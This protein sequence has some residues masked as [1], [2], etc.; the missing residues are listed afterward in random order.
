MNLRKHV[1]QFFRI[2][3]SSKDKKYKDEGG[4]EAEGRGEVDGK[5]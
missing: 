5:W 2:S 3:R 4:Q 1:F